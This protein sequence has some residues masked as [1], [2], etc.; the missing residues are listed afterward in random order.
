MDTIC[1]DHDQSIGVE[2]VSSQ[3]R[4]EFENGYSRHAAPCHAMVYN[5]HSIYSLNDVA[6]VEMTHRAIRFNVI[7]NLK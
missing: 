5:F 4:F 3:P 1:D 2:L 6:N 7:I